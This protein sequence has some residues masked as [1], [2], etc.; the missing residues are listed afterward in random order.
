MSS[1]PI[2]RDRDAVRV[3]TDIVHDLLRS[4]ERALGVDDPFSLPQHGERVRPGGSILEWRERS[5]EA[6]CLGVVRS[7]EVLQEEAT[8]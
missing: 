8:E 3:A 1:K 2:V 4:G 7:L 5:L 6:E